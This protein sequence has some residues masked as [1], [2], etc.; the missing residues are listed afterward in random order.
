MQVR[1]KKEAGKSRQKFWEMAGSKMASI[2]GLTEE[3]AAAAAEAQA[4]AA[5]EDGGAG[6]GDYKA[7]GQ[8][9]TH[10]KKSEGATAFSRGRSVAQQ[11]RSLPIYTVREELLQVRDMIYLRY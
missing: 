5:E 6:E 1:E 3:E 8:F 10:L 4:R 11:R 7:A 2:T 9:R